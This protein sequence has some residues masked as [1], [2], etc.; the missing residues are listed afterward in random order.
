MKN[1]NLKY[2]KLLNQIKNAS[3]FENY[4][5]SI[6]LGSGLGNFASKIEIINS[7]DTSEIVDYPPSTVVGHAGKIHFAK[8]GKKK[9]LL[10]Q[11]RIHFY[12]GY[13]IDESVLPVFIAHNLNCKNIL[14]TN[15][16][17][18]VNPEFSAGDLMLT[19]SFI[20]FNIKKELTEL[21]GLANIDSRNRMKDFPSKYLNE[22]IKSAALK[23]K[24]FLKEG[25]YWYNTG[26]TYE[27][28]A[29]V[30]MSSKSGADAVGMSTAHEAIFASYLGM[31]VC[32]I[33]CITNMAAGISPVKLSHSEVTETANR[34]A[35]IFEELVKNFIKLI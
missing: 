22:K 17:G 27:T 13:K 26:P 24:V 9:I 1:L 5:I 30:Q 14:L 11:G 15:A 12:E 21:I 19:N 29:E 33:S 28:S 2:H 31:N 4:D 23:S 32:A 6:I 7:L 16:A 25:V 3:P 20:S 34:V 18:G 8:Y 35:E 10:F